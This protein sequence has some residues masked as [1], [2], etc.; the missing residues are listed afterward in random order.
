MVKRRI[1]LLLLPAGDRDPG[2]RSGSGLDRELVAKTARA[3]QPE[4]KPA[5]GGVAVGQREVDVG[6][7]GAAVLENQPQAPAQSILNRLHAHDAAAPIVQRVAGDLAGRGDK[8]RLV[9]DPESR[10]G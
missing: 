9:D 8:F 6:D 1:R 5:A 2:A 3:A 10:S 4:A 7:A